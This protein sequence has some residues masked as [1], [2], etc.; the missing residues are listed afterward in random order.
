LF[1]GGSDLLD[2]PLF[3]HLAISD[4]VPPFRLPADYVT[5]HLHVLDSTALIAT[6]LA[7]NGA[8]GSV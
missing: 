1:T 2:K 8:F 5:H 3:E 7:E 4:S 6:L